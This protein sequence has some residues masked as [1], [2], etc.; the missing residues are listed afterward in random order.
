MYFYKLKTWSIISF[1]ILSTI[2]TACTG[3]APSPIVPE[4]GTSTETKE[5]DPLPSN[6]TDPVVGEPTSPPTIS[7]VVSTPQDPTAQPT[8]VPPVTE[9]PVQE[10][11]PLAAGSPIEITYFTPPQM[12][13]PYYTVQK[14]DDRDN[15]LVQVAG[16]SGFPQG[17]ILVFGGKVYDASGMPVEGLTIEIWQTDAS[18]V[19]L[20]PNDPGTASRDPNFQF[21]G[22]ALTDAAGSYSFRT[23]LP[24]QYEPRPPH[25]HFKVKRD[26]QEL[27][28]SQFYFS[29]NPDVQGAEEALLITTLPG[30]DADG[31]SILTG[32]RD[33]ILNQTL[34]N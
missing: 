11:T 12:E 5:P 28:T 24:G 25:I 23:I 21:Y 33:I 18:G 34:T 15:D 7:T 9:M 19:Y 3:E 10:E 26:G 2:L 6:T 30:Q 22:E 17:Q 8:E 16:A 4:S 20:H 14:P 1:F 32:N 31:N 13:G 27:L 29:E